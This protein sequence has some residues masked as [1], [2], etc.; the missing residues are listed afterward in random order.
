MHCLSLTRAEFEFMYAARSGVT[1]AEAFGGE[2][3]EYVALHCE[4]DADSCQ[5]WAAVCN[6]P[7]SLKAHYDLYAPWG[8][9]VIMRRAPE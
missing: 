5:G 1:V 7:L 2:H 6:T 3:P 8:G 9:H 4:C